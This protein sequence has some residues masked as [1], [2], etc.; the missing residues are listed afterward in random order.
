MFSVTRERIRQIEAI[1]FRKLQH[2]TR[3]RTLSLFLN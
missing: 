3:A 1:A 2:P